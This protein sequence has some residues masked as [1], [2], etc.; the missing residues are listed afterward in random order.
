ML[1]TNKELQIIQQVIDNAVKAGIFQNLESAAVVWKAWG[2]VKY[3]VE[4]S[5]TQKNGDANSIGNS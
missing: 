1:N 4:Q 5:E 3:I 2:T